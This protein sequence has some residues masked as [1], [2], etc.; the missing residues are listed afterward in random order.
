MT[1]HISPED[2]SKAS[3][4]SGFAPAGRHLCEVAS[5]FEKTSAKGDPGINLL[6]VVVGG[7]FEGM[8]AC[9]DM[10]MLGGKGFGIG[11]SKLKALG[12]D[13]SKPFHYSSGDLRGRRAFITTVNRTYKKGDGTAA[14]SPSPIFDSKINF[15]YEAADGAVSAASEP[16]QEVC[17]CGHADAFHPDAKKCTIQG[18]ACGTFES[19]PF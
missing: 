9:Y 3:T 6:W 17:V 19:T 5:D 13:F 16:S 12:V 10:V 2:A 8:P 15:G 11:V 1:I 18:C 14:S 7:E 4:S